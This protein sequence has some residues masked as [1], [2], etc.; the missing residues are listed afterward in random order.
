[1]GAPVYIPAAIAAA[2][3]LIKGQDPLTA[4]QN[5]AIAGAT[6]GIMQ[7]AEQFIPAFQG[8]GQATAASTANAGGNFLASTEAP[9]GMFNTFNTATGNPLTNPAAQIVGSTGELAPNMGL[10]N[11]MAAPDYTPLMTK[12]GQ[13]VSEGGL[14]ARNAPGTAPSFFDGLSDYLTPQ[15][16]L[17]VANMMDQQSSA[18]QMSSV[19][20]GG[21]RGGNADV[22]ETIQQFLQRLGAK[23]QSPN[24]RQGL[25]Y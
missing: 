6:G 25:F 11:P 5:G 1:M 23:A 14:A 12:M 15:N 20:G 18:P 17:G 19:G 16:V 8:A 4:A 3:S 9:I 24:R 22:G 21:V 10:V 13:G 2:N 7:G